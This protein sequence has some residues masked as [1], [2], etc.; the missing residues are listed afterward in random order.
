MCVC[1]CASGVCALG[2]RRHVHATAM[3]FTP[4]VSALMGQYMGVLLNWIA[5]GSAL[6][7]IARVL[8]VYVPAGT[9]SRRSASTPF[10]YTGATTRATTGRQHQHDVKHAC[11]PRVARRNQRTMRHQVT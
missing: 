6:P 8:V 7:V 4:T 11:R 1:A 3:M 10:K 2:H 9:F 5:P